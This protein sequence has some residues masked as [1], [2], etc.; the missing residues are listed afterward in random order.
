V[1]A[2]VAISHADWERK[3]AAVLA[4]IA[5]RPGRR[6]N[7]ADIPP[8]PTPADPADQPNESRP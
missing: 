8:E 5:R 6:T 4:D 2:P 7:L 1:S 3:L